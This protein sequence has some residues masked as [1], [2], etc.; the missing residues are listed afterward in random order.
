MATTG[1]DDAAPDRL[2]G[3]ALDEAA[4]RFLVEQ[5]DELGVAVHLL[6]GGFEGADR[7]GRRDP[8]TGGVGAGGPQEECRRLTTDLRRLLGDL[9]ADLHAVGKGSV[10]QLRL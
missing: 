6:L 8:R 1:S 10:G 2:R 7:R 4:G 5:G 9:D 3:G